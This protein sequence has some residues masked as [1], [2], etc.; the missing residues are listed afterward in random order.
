MNVDVQDQDKSRYALILFTLDPGKDMLDAMVSTYGLPPSWMDIPLYRE[1]MPGKSVTFKATI[2]EGPV[3][4]ACFSKPPDIVIGA[5]GPFEVL[6][7]PAAVEATP[8]VVEGPVSE[9][10][11]SFTKGSCKHNGPLSLRP[12]EIAV[13]IDVIDENVYALMFFTLDPGKTLQD[14]V[15]AQGMPSPPPWAKTIS[16]QDTLPGTGKTYDISVEEGPVYMLC[17]DE[18]RVIKSMTFDVEP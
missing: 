13:T 12:G 4:G 8:T 17:W 14:L 3:Y 16:M 11:V 1:I 5:M 15:A 2:K 6:P 10:L 18:A 9:L 7:A